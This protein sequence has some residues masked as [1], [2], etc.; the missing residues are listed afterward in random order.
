M[1]AQSWKNIE[2][3]IIPYPGKTIGDITPE[4]IR[5]GYNPLR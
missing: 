2:E 3:L 1:W 5:Q 4:L